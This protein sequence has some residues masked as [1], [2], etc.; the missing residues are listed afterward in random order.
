[1]AGEHILIID[2]SA[3][4]RSIARETLENAGYVVTT[5]G[6]AAAA[7][8]APEFQQY[9]VVLLDSELEG[10]SGV[11]AARE[12]RGH[13]AQQRTPILLLIPEDKAP[14]RGSVDAGAADGYL[15]KPFAPETLALKVRLLVERRETLALAEAQMRAEA[16]KH[17]QAFI[18]QHIQ[19]ALDR[20]L[21][22]LAETSVQSVLAR[23]EQMARDE[24]NRRVV[25]LSAQKE[26]ELIRK[27]VDEV[28]RAT[29]SERAASAIHE[30]INEVLRDSTEKEVQ[31]A[32]ARVLPAMIR[33]RIKET[34]ENML[35]REINIRVQRATEKLAPE[36]SENIVSMVTSVS[37]KVIP[38]LA[39]ER[40]P[41]I[42]D[43]QVDASASRAVPPLVE[44]LAPREVDKRISQEIEPLIREAGARIRRQA[45]NA[46]I[47]MAA[48]FVVLSLILGVSA[49]KISHKAA[50]PPAGESAAPSTR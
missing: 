15:L 25:G 24:V 7:L 13:P 34:S 35:P 29:I 2:D 16:E 33:E 20:Q 47:L 41:E 42:L 27:T 43:K 12:M 6:N 28:A 23:V 22:I 9:A 4:T 26:E 21:Q 8:L 36:L 5:A 1:M 50:P 11:R 40:L 37:E 48:V 38:K 46:L 10:L 31:R 49:W 19:K 45:R 44:R 3:A 17:V 32:A 14:E 39:R 30:T 18:E